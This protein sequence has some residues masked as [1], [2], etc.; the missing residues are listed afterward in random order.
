M[1]TLNKNFSA[2]SEIIYSDVTNVLGL[3][4]KVL[5]SGGLQL[6]ALQ[7]EPSSAPWQISASSS[8]FKRDL[9]LGKAEL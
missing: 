7:A 8:C 9:L 6:W 1:S 3:H 4:V 5:V 2:K